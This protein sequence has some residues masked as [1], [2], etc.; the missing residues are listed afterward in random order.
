MCPRLHPKMGPVGFVLCWEHRDALSPGWVVTR[1]GRSCYV[2]VA[3]L[4]KNEKSTKFP[5]WQSAGGGER[6]CSQSL[7]SYTRPAAFSCTL[8]SLLLFTF[9]PMSASRIV[10]TTLYPICSPRY[11]LRKK[12]LL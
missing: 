5:K 11:L 2:E 12:S 7:C 9:Q 6:K 1:G 3:P 8:Y 10:P 4:H